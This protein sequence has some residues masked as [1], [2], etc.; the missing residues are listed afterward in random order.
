[1]ICQ[2]CGCNEQSDLG[3]SELVKCHLNTE[4][5]PKTFL[6]TLRH[7]YL[8]SPALDALLSVDPAA[9]H[10]PKKSVAR[11]RS[12]IMANLTDRI[13][14]QL[15]AYE[16]SKVGFQ[17]ENMKTS[18][19]FDGGCLKAHLF[20]IM[21]SH[22]VVLNEHNSVVNLDKII[23]ESLLRVSVFKYIL[24]VFYILKLVMERTP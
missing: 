13:N 7:I 21:W 11:V 8:Q 4:F 23:C 1:M 22:G 18:F 20:C 14:S 24:K 2:I 10:R 5:D 15:V 6:K 3:Q 19:F 12:N 17:I 9:I 16:V